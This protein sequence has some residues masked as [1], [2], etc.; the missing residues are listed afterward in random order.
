MMSD[1]N[2]F[3]QIPQL[4]PLPPFPKGGLLGD[5]VVSLGRILVLSKESTTKKTEDQ[6]LLW[7]DPIK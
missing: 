5:L 7:L 6:Y 4:S 1:R 2:F 3:D